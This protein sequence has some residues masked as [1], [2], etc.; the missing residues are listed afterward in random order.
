MPKRGKVSVPPTGS[1]ELDEVYRELLPTHSRDGLYVSLAD[2]QR[3][4]LERF[5]QKRGDINGRV[6]ETKA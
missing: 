2:I 4:A 1:Y 3:R 5:G 6:E